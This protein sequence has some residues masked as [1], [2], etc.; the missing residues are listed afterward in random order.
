MPTPTVGDKIRIISIIGATRRQGHAQHNTTPH[1]IHLHTFASLLLCVSAHSTHLSFPSRAVAPKKLSTQTREE[2][3]ETLL[4]LSSLSFSHSILFVI[5]NTGNLGYNTIM[6]YT[7]KLPRRLA[8][9]SVFII[10]VVYSS[11]LLG[12]F[13][14]KPQTLHLFL[15]EQHTHKKNIISQ[16]IRTYNLHDRTT[17]VPLPLYPIL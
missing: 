7:N 2:I 17:S 8:D 5:D 9:L 15:R 6:L 13:K 10:A 1:S 11:T 16:S 14:C 12:S 3:T 4:N